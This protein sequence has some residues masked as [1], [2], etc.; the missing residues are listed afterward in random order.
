MRL[1]TETWIMIMTGI[2]IVI[3]YTTQSLSVGIL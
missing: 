1:G 2:G 3:V